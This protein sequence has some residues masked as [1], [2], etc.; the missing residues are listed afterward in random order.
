M[1][2]GEF[3]NL[4]AGHAPFAVYAV[5]RCRLPPF[6]SRE[7]RLLHRCR[8][9]MVSAQGWLERVLKAGILS[10]LVHLP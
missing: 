1:F 6:G 2:L 8:E 3:E 7:A 9:Q 5:E 4:L 10:L